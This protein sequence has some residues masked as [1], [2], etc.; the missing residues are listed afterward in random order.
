LSYLGELRENIRPLAAASLGSGT[1]MTLYAYATSIFAPHL[2]GTFGWSRA[3]FALIGLAMLTA[4]LPLPF[5]GRFT[6]RFGVRRVATVGTLLLPFCFIGFA[7][8]QGSFGYFVVF[9]SLVA[10]IGSMTSTL[11]YTRLIA[12][13]FR[14]AQG[15]ALTIVNCTPSALAIAVVPLLNWSIET[16]GWRV[17]YLGFG[18]F[19]LAGG[20]TALLL[21]PRHEANR[22]D[23]RTAEIAPRPAREE[24]AIIFRSRFFWIILAAMF[25]CLLG[26]PLH[27]SQMNVM[28]LENGITAQTASNIVS[29]YAFATIL[30]RLACGLALDRFSTPY[31]TAVSMVLPAFGFFLLATDLDTLPVIVAAMFLVGLTVGAEN[32]V[33]SF[34]VA[35]YFK[36]RIYSSTLSVLFFST[37]LAT[38]TGAGA[39]SLTLKLAGS[40][41]PYMFLVSGSVLAGSLLFLLLPRARNF[42]KIG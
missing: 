18:G 27:S 35:R 5:I 21:I 16:L 9:S 4:L 3:Q 26:S 22:A 14:Q 33:I 42:E 1:G 29:V 25:L 30:G 34:L 11:V 12:G 6:D 10:I 23:V 31:V 19:V 24:F 41:S 17:S 13:N 15:L 40:F 28:L 2:I 20:V 38:A 37:F 36:L 8:Q 39:I 32:D 7:L